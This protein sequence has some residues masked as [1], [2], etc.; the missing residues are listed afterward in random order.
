[1]DQ[2]QRDIAQQ[3]ADQAWAQRAAIINEIRDISR[4]VYDISGKP[5]A[6]IEW[7]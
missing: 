1:M 3:H 5:P 7:E 2:W 4:V 6:T